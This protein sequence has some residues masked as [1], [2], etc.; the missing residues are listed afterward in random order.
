MKETVV[1]YITF[2]KINSNMRVTDLWK[3]TT[4][5]SVYIFQAHKNT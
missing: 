1:P 3:I 4:E 5:K 2:K